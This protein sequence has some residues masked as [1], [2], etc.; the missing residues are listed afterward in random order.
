MRPLPRVRLSL[1]LIDWETGVNDLWHWHYFFGY[2]QSSEMLQGAWTTVWLTLVTM[3]LGIAIGV[4]AAVGKDFDHP[5]LNAIYSVYVTLIRGTPVLMQLV[6][7]YTV[8]PIFG[9]RLPVN[10]A[11]VLAL[12]VNEGAYVAEIMRGGIESIPR[13]Q[14]DAA[15]VTGFGYWKMMAIVILPQA[16]RI[17]VPTLGNQVNAMFKSTSL[18]SVIS[19]T[20]LFRVTEELTQESFRFLEAYAA[21]ALMYLLMTWVWTLIQARLERVAY[22]PGTGPA[23]RPPSTRRWFA[24]LRPDTRG[25]TP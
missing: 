4:I 23:P 17:V 6:F 14:R 2:L 11:A 16:T 12:S 20:D 18:A 10:A 21:A 9:I 5:V 22:I 24:H 15:H 3:A 1:D 19:V 25:S 7:A 8:L 13:G